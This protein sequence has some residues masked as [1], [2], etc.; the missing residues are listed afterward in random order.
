MIRKITG[1]WLIL[2]ISCAAMAA[3]DPARTDW[4]MD[5]ALGLFVHWSVDSQ[6]GS[7]ISHS[8]VG[9]A[10]DYAERF[11]NE[12]PKTFDPQRFDPNEWARLAKVAGMKYVV[13]TTKHHS[14]FCMFDTR[15]TDFDIMS[16]PY[17]KDIT[18]QLFTALRKQGIA[19]GVYFSPDDFWKLYQQGIEI[20]RGRPEVLP[21]NNP[22]L[23]AHNKAQLRELFTNYGPIDVLFID[24][25]PDGLR[26]L[27]WELQPDCVITRGAMETPEQGTPDQPMPGPWEACYT[28]TLHKIR[29]SDVGWDLIEDV[30]Q[31]CFDP[32]VGADRECQETLW[33]TETAGAVQQGLAEC[34]HLLEDPQARSFG[35]RASCARGGLHLQFSRQIVGEQF[36][37]QIG[38]IAI[39]GTHRHVIEVAVG[40]QLGE[41]SFLGAASLVEGHHSP[42]SDGLVRHD[43]L[44]LIP[45]LVGHEQVQ[46]DRT[47]LLFLRPGANEHEAEP[48]VPALGFPGGLE[49]AGLVVHASPASALLDHSLE[50][51]ESLEG[52]ADREL[53][54]LPRQGRDD[55]I[56]EE[57]AVHADFDL[58]VRQD[59]PN[60]LDTGQKER[61]GPMGIMHVARSKEE[62]EDLSG[63]GDRTEQ[64][65]I[66]AGSF[67][68]LVESHGGSFG[69]SLGG[70][71][72]T[73]EV[74][75]D[76]RG[77]ECPEA[78]QN[79]LSQEAPE[80][81]DAL[82]GGLLEG[83]TDGGHRGK[84][85]EPQEAL[86]QWIVPIVSPILQFT[87]AQE[88]MNDQL[89]EHRGG[90]E[91]LPRTPRL[92][93]ATQSALEINA[94]EELL[95]EDQP[96]EGGQGLILESQFGQS[97]GFTLD[98]GS[99]ILHGDLPVL[100]LGP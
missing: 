73:V 27:A 66:A 22:G 74:Q 54:P 34:A 12:L 79:S 99:W 92:E 45:V 9:A 7:V 44:E 93:A 58:R 56:A 18:R 31:A 68:L 20:S 53:D 63:L 94:R 8:L 23:M 72:G 21:T 59:G 60:R 1:L 75:R 4:F 86:D 64:R 70:E 39:E 3:N 32:G 50:F 84:S 6:L 100:C 77:L 35:R 85:P 49:V 48:S 38:L 16:T 28:L 46:L 78:I 52:D 62:I 89:Q 29:R 71:H 26:E 47:F 51:H 30:Q 43:H 5:Q 95:E 65:V 82:G 2:S 83:P 37:Q 42:G 13:F 98:L 76:P 36:G 87:K 80:C 17:G 11:F 15:T 67:L 61:F 10:P 40:L 14:G 88:Q 96:G 91:H 19:V 41:D 25:E 33:P 69:A 57:G 55:R 24:G 97:V 81:F 90:M